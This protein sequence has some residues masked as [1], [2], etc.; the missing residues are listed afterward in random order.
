M[1]PIK[2]Q[3]Q[4]NIF[5]ITTYLLIAVNTVIFLFLFFMNQD[6]L[7]LVID[8]YALVP[9]EILMGKR[10][11]TLITSMFLHGSFGHLF[12]NMLFLN[13]FGRNMEERLGRLGFLLFYIVSGVIGA[14]T[15]ILVMPDNIPVLG[16]SAAI[17]GLLGAYIIFFPTHK[18]DIV[19]FL[20]FI[21]KIIALPAI[22]LLVI[23]ALFQVILGIG[24]I[25]LIGTGI[26]YFAHVGGFSFGVL[27]ALYLSIRSKSKL[28]EPIYEKIP[29]RNIRLGV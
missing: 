12:G 21:I 2:D 5:P 10:L 8:K 22:T 23:W 1:F 17:S 11:Y 9:D 15:Q 16:A 29:N 28:Q 26:A 18:I 20:G 25:E 27:T 24:E 14:M 3:E 7:T 13:I 6:K 19:L 4:P